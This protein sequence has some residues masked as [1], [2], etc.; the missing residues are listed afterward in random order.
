[1]LSTFLSI[2][3]IC[4]HSIHFSIRQASAQVETCQ[5]SGVGAVAEKGRRREGG[6]VD[7]GLIQHFGVESIGR[8]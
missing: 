7:S 4:F 5:G 8:I 1:M 2:P 3:A 6:H